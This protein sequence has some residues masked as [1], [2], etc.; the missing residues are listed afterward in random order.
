[1]TSKASSERVVCQVADMDDNGILIDFLG[2]TLK[3]LTLMGHSDLKWSVFDLDWMQRQD[4]I[5][6]WE[7]VCE[8]SRERP[9][10]WQLDDNGIRLF[11]T[12]CTQVI[13]GLFLAGSHHVPQP[14]GQSEE[15]AILRSEIAL[16]AFDSSFW[17][18]SCSDHEVA[19]NI[20]GNFGRIKWTPLVIHSPE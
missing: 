6:H 4:G 13:D 20:I 8:R 19:K 14:I 5:L 9:D 18:L 3:R 12:Q 17:R 10:G 11:H 2:H 1:V 7:R 15:C 16:Q